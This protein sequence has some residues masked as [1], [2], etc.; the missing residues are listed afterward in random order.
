[1]RT[2]L[3]IGLLLTAT[4]ACG[5]GSAGDW[6]PDD[7]EREA[8]LDTIGDAGYAKLCGAFEDYVLDMYRTSYLVQAACTAIAVENTAD[9]AACGESVQACLDNPPAEATALVDMILAQAGCATVDVEPTGC[10]ATVR[11]VESCLDALGAEVD[12]VEFTLTCAAAGQSLDDSWWQIDRP[13]SCSSLSIC[14]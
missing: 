5:G 1:M 7:L 14:E 4:G 6:L 2:A 3:L 12:Q 11:Q 9:A 13:S 8:T 10:S